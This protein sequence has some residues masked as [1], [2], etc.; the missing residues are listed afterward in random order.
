MRPVRLCQRAQHTGVEQQQLQRSSSLGQNKSTP[1][2]ASSRPEQC[3]GQEST[4]GGVG[5]QI[6]VHSD[7]S[8]H[9]HSSGTLSQLQRSH[10]SLVIIN[11]DFLWLPPPL[12]LHITPC[13]PSFVPMSVS[14]RPP[15][16]HAST[17]RHEP[18]D[19][20]GFMACSCKVSLTI[21]RR[22]WGVEGKISDVSWQGTDTG[23]IIWFPCYSSH[24]AVLYNVMTESKTFK[25]YQ[26]CRLLFGLAVNYF[27]ILVLEK[28]KTNKLLFGFGC[29]QV[30]AN[31]VTQSE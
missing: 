5:A 25:Q 27:N 13:S 10:C 11:T 31:Q 2:P 30:T 3:Q 23:L 6:S 20:G 26:Q 4:T 12:H 7:S 15:W 1:H 16:I 8:R 19:T 24:S 28:N 29:F 9:G 18:G 17:S 22:F 21:L 14:P